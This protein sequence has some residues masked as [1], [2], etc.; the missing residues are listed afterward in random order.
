MKK[1]KVENGPGGG[2]DIGYVGEEG[3]EQ[4]VVESGAAAGGED[5]EQIG[6]GGAGCQPCRRSS[7][8]SPVKAGGQQAASSVTSQCFISSVLMMNCYACYCFSS[9][10]LP[11]CHGNEPHAASSIQTIRGDPCE[12]LRESIN[13]LTAH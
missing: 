11:V 6:E 9:L 10:S 2:D 8:S 1:E 3:E 5:G 7:S 12:G 4:T 13:T